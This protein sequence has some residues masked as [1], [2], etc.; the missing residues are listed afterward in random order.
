MEP[1]IHS[2]FVIERSY[3]KPPETVFAA[4]SDPNKYRRWFA[5]GDSH[6][7]VEFQLDF[8]QGGSEHILYRLNETTPFPGVALSNDGVYQN[9]IPNKLIV[10]A[11]NM[12]LG[13][14]RISASLVTIE[15]LPTATG[16]DLVCTHQGAFFEGADGPKMREVGWRSLFEK[17]A[18]ELSN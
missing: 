16:T 12:N 6:D 15:L 1:V 3:P 9:I 4:F 10:T 2:T 7:L 13:D 14:K 8:R 18:K 11:S 17:L 5:S